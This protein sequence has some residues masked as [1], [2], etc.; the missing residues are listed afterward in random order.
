VSLKASE[1]LHFPL[2]WRKTV[3]LSAQAVDRIAV[4]DVK[5][6]VCI[7]LTISLG[8]AICGVIVI[9]VF[10]DSVQLHDFVN[11]FAAFRRLREHSSATKDVQVRLT[12]STKTFYPS[13]V[14]AFE[15]PLLHRLDICD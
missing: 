3:P 14:H 12:G 11:R 2:G 8:D 1:I 9:V 5:Q 15:A 6:R 13:T 10:R 4:T 7:P